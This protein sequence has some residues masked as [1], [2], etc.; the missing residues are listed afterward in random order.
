ILCGK[1][2]AEV[3]SLLEKVNETIKITYV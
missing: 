3:R 2:H 1:D